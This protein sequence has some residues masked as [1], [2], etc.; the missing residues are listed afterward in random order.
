MG[1]RR[2]RERKERIIMGTEVPFKQRVIASN[3]VYWTREQ[4]VAMGDFEFARM[5]NLMAQQVVVDKE[6]C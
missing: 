5:L 6:G 1:G 3:F 2:E 4:R